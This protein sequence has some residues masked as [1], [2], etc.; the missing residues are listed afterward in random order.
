MFIHKKDRTDL[1][2]TLDLRVEDVDGGRY[3]NQAGTPYYVR[4]Y[5]WGTEDAMNAATGGTG[6]ALALFVCTGV[7]ECVETARW[8]PMRPLLGEVHFFR[9]AWTE[10]VVAH[11][12]QH[13]LNHR[14]RV[15]PCGDEEPPDV[16]HGTGW[17]QVML[18][19]MDDRRNYFAR[20]GAE[21]EHCHLAGRWFAAVYGWLWEHD[22]HGKHATTDPDP[23]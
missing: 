9:G 15:L 5:L 3:V 11:E 17:R 23:A 4:C 14:L 13:A 1:L 22:A 18:N 19:E 16:P 7:A 2:A 10:E 8:S 20:D 21:E 12:I 6:D